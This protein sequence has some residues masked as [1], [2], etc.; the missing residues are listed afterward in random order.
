[1]VKETII[2]INGNEVEIEVF[3][4]GFRKAN[5]IAK[6]HIPINSLTMGKDDKITINGDIDLFGMAESCLS[7]IKGLDLDKISSEEAN[8]IYKKYFEKDVM[9]GLGNPDPNSKRS[10]GSS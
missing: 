8:R 6:K 7:E 5:A 9:A 3:R 10:S 2:D 1:M 4:L